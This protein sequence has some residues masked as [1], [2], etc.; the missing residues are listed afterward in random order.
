MH[1]LIVNHKEKLDY[2]KK[3]L[4]TINF[5]DE[6]ASLIITIKRNKTFKILCLSLDLK[7]FKEENMITCEYYICKSLLKN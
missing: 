6:S 5:N 3:K 4:E 2:I 1:F 7:R